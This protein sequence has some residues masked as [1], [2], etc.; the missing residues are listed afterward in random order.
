MAAPPAEVQNVPIRSVGVKATFACAL[1]EEGALFAW[2]QN[3]SFEQPTA[4][5]EGIEQAVLAPN[6]AIA[7]LK[8]GI[9]SYW[10]PETGEVIPFPETLPEI[11]QLKPAFEGV[12]VECAEGKRLFLGSDSPAE[13]PKV[14]ELSIGE[15][16]SNLPEEAPYAVRYCNNPRV[17][18]VYTIEEGRLRGWSHH[19]EWNIDLSRAEGI[20]DFVDVVFMKGDIH[21]DLDAPFA[22]AALRA[23]GEVIVGDGCDETLGDV[24]R[25]LPGPSNFSLIREDGSLHYYNPNTRRFEPT[26]LDGA[27][28]IR[29]AWVQGPT[30][31]LAILENGELR[32]WGDW[33]DSTLNWHEYRIVSA[34]A[35]GRHGLAV[36]DEGRLLGWNS[37]GELDIPDELQNGVAEVIGGGNHSFVR[38]GQDVYLYHQDEGRFRIID[39]LE[40]AIE[41][42]QPGG[43]GVVIRRSA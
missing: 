29:D 27:E 20:T 9:V 25:L 4:I 8:N 38:K 7:I 32:L 5:Q 26:P 6:Q 17:R 37:E 22:W 34:V 12:V 13:R 36:T 3:G 18:Q 11:K 39:R 42:M 43:Q 24:T 35:N 23:N 41:E 40:G 15:R 28:P 14:P 16:I 21:Q 30:A 33:V 10:Y 19:P 2:G 31:G 1:T